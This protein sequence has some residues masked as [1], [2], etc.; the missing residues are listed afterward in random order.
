ML[1]VKTDEI[2]DR[3]NDMSVFIGVKGGNVDAVHANQMNIETSLYDEIPE[4]FIAS[5]IE[6]HCD[7]IMKRFFH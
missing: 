4:S 7:W 2:S 1:V 5:Q 3:V 6:T